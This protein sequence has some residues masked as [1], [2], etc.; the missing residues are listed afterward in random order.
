MAET[1]ARD[2]APDLINAFRLS[3]FTEFELTGEKGA[4]AVGH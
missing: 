3:R 4:A 1:V 2:K